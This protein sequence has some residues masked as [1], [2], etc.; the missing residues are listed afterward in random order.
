[1]GF[2]SKF[3]ELTGFEPMKWQTRLYSE[4]FESG[5][6]PGTIDIPTGLGKTSVMAIWYLALKAGACLPMRLVYVVDRRAVVD[7]ATTVADEIKKKSEDK[8]LRV[9]TL[10]GQHVDNREWLENPTSPAIIIGTVD[11]IG[12]RILF[13]GYGVSR[14]MRPYHAGLLGADTLVVLDESHLVPPFERLLEAIENGAE[15]LGPHEQVD[16]EI[17]PPFKLLSLSATGQAR[18]DKKDEDFHLDENKGDLD[19]E[20]VKTRLGAKKHLTIESANNKKLEEVLAEQAW[21]LSGDGE[22]AARILVYCNSRDVAQKTKKAIE[23]KVKDNKIEIELF[24]GARRVKERVDAAERLETLGFLGDG[25]ITL[26]KPAFLI[27]TSAGEVGVDLDADHMVCDL[28]AW[29]RMVQRLGRVNRRGGPSRKAEIHVVTVKLKKPEVEEPVLPPSE[30]PEAPEK[31]GRLAKSADEQARIDH[32]TKKQRYDADNKSY[33]VEKKAFD[34]KCKEYPEKRRKYEKAWKEY[35]LFEAHRSAIECLIGDASSGAIQNLKIRAESDPI[36]REKVEAATTPS[37]LYPALTRALV[38]AW[39]MT[40]LKEHTGR[41]E[42]TPWLRGWVDDKPQTVIVWR[43]YLPVRT[44]G[45]EASKKEVEDFFEAAPPHLSEKLETETW[46]VSK[47]LASRANAVSKAK[48]IEPGQIVGFALEPDGSLRKSF[49]LRDFVKEDDKK[50][51]KEREDRIA[52]ATLIIDASLGGLKAGLLPDVDAAEHNEGVR[53]ADDGDEWPTDPTDVPL[54]IHV[55]QNEGSL[56]GSVLITHTFA[57]KRSSEGEDIERLFIE[58]KANADSRA[59][60][61]HSQ[62]LDEHLS[63]A[64]ACARKIAE[65]AGL[66]GDHADVVAIAAR[67]HDEGK[68]A[69]RWQCAFNAR[70]D[71]LYAKTKGPINFSRLGKYRHEFGS[72]PNAEKDEA[73]KRLPDHLQELVLHLIAAHHGQARP[74]IETRGCDDAPPFLL[75]TRAREVAL[76]F[77]RLQKRWGPWGLAWWESLLRAADQQSSR[78][79]DNRENSHG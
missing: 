2:E 31:V 25:D 68:K 13:S 60:S 54:R 35:W 40:S 14:K 12:S 4:C 17:V 26:D 79:N 55:A 1:M 30:P 75:K 78:D 48:Q 43:K 44:V 42:V 9:S 67:L 49:S 18:K 32:A 63:W 71:G 62:L 76:R 72:L 70:H 51:E 11:M 58:T 47:W 3:K 53:T 20:V 24:V 37:P 34:K 61:R 52:G 69:Q 39:S 33:N 10:R 65:A 77:A 56:D 19:D 22:K 59:T 45:S 5:D 28:V 23:A 27:A 46:R 57:T 6:I 8:Q 50:R 66:T 29:E 16:C 36:L 15:S 21:K 41:P 64:E 38:D 7:Q 73:L 74:V